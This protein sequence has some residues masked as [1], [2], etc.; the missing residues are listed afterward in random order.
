MYQYDELCDEDR[1][2]LFTKNE[3]YASLSDRRSSVLV[4]ASMRPDAD[5]RQLLIPLYNKYGKPGYGVGLVLRPSVF[6]SGGLLCSYT[7]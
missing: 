7:R 1:P 4:Y 3:Q 5:Q 6:V 2:W